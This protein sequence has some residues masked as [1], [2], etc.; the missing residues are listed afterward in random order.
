MST[1]EDG[2]SDRGFSD[3]GSYALEDSTRATPA[4][5][6]SSANRRRQTGSG[7]RTR[8]CASSLWLVPIRPTDATP[9]PNQGSASGQ[10]ERACV[11]R[12]ALGWRLKLGSGLLEFMLFRKLGIGAWEFRSAQAAASFARRLGIK[13][14]LVDEGTG[15]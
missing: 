11:I 6:A 13:N 9:P 12:S 14:V 2:I 1:H 5:R 15:V 10:I 7:G 4:R 8:K 3:C